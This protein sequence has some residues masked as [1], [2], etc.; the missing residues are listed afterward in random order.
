MGTA[1]PPFLLSH[2]QAQRLH[3]Y[4][5][6]YRTYALTS[7]LPSPERNTAL[8]VLQGLQSKLIE[9]LDH[10]TIPSYPLSL[11]FAR[12]EAM[13]VKL[14]ATELIALYS[15]QPEGA[16]RIATLS[17]LAALKLSLKQYEKS[18]VYKGHSF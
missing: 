2:D 9:V 3:T 11:S 8:R 13:M 7:L 15:R 1:P 10:A 5:Q 16:E 14:A 17:D 4:I 6:A 18:E 12:E